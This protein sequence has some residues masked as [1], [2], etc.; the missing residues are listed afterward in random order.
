MRELQEAPVFKWLYGSLDTE[1][2]IL[3]FVL[4]DGFDITVN[5]ESAVQPALQSAAISMHASSTSPNVAFKVHAL[6]EQFCFVNAH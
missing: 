1:V 4:S 2:S 6:C 5:L 3:W